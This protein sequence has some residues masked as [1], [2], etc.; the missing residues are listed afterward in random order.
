MA[1]D[2]STENKQ[3]RSQLQ[4]FIEVAR[5]NEEKMRRF[6]DHELSLLG[7]TSLA[8]LVRLLLFQTRAT[9]ALDI[10]TLSLL[11]PEYESARFLNHSGL[12]IEN[13][14]GLIIETSADYLN[15]LYNGKFLPRLE[16]F[17]QL[18]H[19]VLFPDREQW[20][21]SI[22]ILPLVRNNTLIG[23]LNLGSLDSE[24]FHRASGTEFLNRLALVVAICLENSLNQERLK[25]VGLTDPLTRVNNRRFFD[26]RLN[27]EVATCARYP[28]PLICM[29]FDIDHFKQVNDTLGH[30]AGDT[31]LL[32]VAGLMGSQLRPND[33]LCRY[34]GE[35]FVTLLPNTSLEVAF[36]VAQ[37]IRQLVERHSFQL[38]SI[39]STRITISIGIAALSS[40][41]GLTPETA[42][43]SLLRAADEALYRAKD[44]GRNRVELAGITALPAAEQL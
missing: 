42:S 22:A 25:Q 18:D 4:S 13:V 29:F 3:L 39:K 8:E 19:E 36:E 14:P 15:A 26:Q 28:A 11:D 17:R 34:G 24:R 1:S 10:V 31:V 2:L 12:A 35:E 27:E 16:S 41:P 23:S 43:R 32:Q 40:S 37:R 6:N 5:R 21:N 7:T 20:P 33:I 30:Q 44:N 9:F 38:D